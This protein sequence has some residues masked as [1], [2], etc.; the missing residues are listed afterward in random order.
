MEL[1]PSWEAANCAATRELPSILWNP[2][3]HHRIHISPPTVPIL[4]QIDPIHTIPSYL[5]KIH[6]NIVH[7]STSWSSQWS[8]SFWLSHQYPICIPLLATKIFT[9][10]GWF[11][12]LQRTTLHELSCVH[13]PH[14]RLGDISAGCLFASAMK[15]C[16]EK[17]RVTQVHASYICAAAQTCWF[18]QQLQYC[19]SRNEREFFRPITTYY[20][21]SS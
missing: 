11:S 3:V 8:L 5:S 14:S 13:L 21:D 20:D 17:R 12:V 16:S 9:A 1:S 4:S 2:E 19:C 10:V 15:S 6:F 7:P 18:P